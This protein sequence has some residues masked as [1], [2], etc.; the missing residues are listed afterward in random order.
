MIHS[1]CKSSKSAIS[2]RIISFPH[3]EDY[4]LR[5]IQTVLE[6]EA[7]ISRS[8]LCKRVLNSWGIS[9]LGSRIDAY[10]NEL[11]NKI[12]HYP[13]RGHGSFFFWRSEEQMISNDTFRP[14]SE[15]IAH[16][17]RLMKWRMR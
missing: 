4:I 17:W 11:F 16:D 13:K 12:E 5:Q 6:A 2:L 15:R 8:L 14:V 1:V 10:F 9:R 7:P 3:H